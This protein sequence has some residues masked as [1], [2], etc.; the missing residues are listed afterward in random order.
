MFSSGYLT[1]P[2]FFLRIQ[3]KNNT[4]AKNCEVSQETVDVEID[5]NLKRLYKTGLPICNGCISDRKKSITQRPFG[6]TELDT[7]TWKQIW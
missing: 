5:I 7:H 4:I 3:E 6:K 2:T 1:P